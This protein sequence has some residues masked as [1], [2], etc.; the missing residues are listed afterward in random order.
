MWCPA[1][2]RACAA[3]IGWGGLLGI[4]VCAVYWDVLA[5]LARQWASD[6][7]YSHGF[8]I[9]PLAAYFAWERRTVIAALPPQPA[10]WGLAGVLAACG[11]F[12][13]GTIAAEVFIVRLSFVAL[14]AA[15]I[16]F[17]FGSGHLRELRFSVLFLLLMIPL[18]ALLFNQIAFPLQLMASQVGEITLRTAG[19][20][21]LREG[22]VLELEAMRLEVAEA[23]S[24][25]RSLTSLVAF[26]LVLGRF[27]DAP[28]GRQGLLVLSTIP[29]ALIAN[30]ARVAAT[31]VAAHTWGRAVVDGAFH[32][33]AGA[34]VFV[35]AVAT[36]LAIQRFS[37]TPRVA[38]S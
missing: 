19:I 34:L 36:I 22:N 16:A 14:V 27:N 38:V 20:P 10:S 7:N 12:A 33:A 8:L 3:R 11:L 5:G 30:A 25:I 9:A 24:G 37:G 18:P 2:S 29:V 23:C 13:L 17:L 28:P 32:T 4:A 1:V 21:V 26:A 6:E 15:S 35:A 31:G